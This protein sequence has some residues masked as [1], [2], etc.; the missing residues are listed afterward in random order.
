MSGRTAQ[1]VIL[2]ALEGAAQAF[3]ALTDDALLVPREFIDRLAR[4]NQGD[5][6]SLDQL[7]QRAVDSTDPNWRRYL[8]TSQT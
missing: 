4:Q 7:L 3:A 5:F 8:G 2:H 6:V 1:R